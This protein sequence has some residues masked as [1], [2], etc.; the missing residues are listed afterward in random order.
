MPDLKW[1]HNYQHQ[2]KQGKVRVFCK[3]CGKGSRWFDA[4]T[5]Q[6]LVVKWCNDHHGLREKKGL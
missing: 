4:A 1:K 5:E 6:E 3:P 2:C